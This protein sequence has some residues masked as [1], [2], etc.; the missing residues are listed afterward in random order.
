MPIKNKLRRKG[1][2]FQNQEAKKG[3]YIPLAEAIRQLL[4]QEQKDAEDKI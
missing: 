2:K 3:K 1:I 4:I